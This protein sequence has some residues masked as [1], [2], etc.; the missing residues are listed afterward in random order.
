MVVIQKQCQKVQ[1]VNFRRLV[2][3]LIVRDYCCSAVLFLSYNSLRSPAAP[4][5]MSTASAPVAQWQ[6]WSILVTPEV[7][8]IALG[9]RRMHSTDDGASE[10]GGCSLA[11]RERHLLGY[12][13]CLVPRGEPCPQITRAFCFRGNQR[14]STL[15]EV[16]LSLHLF[17]S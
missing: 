7:T 16:R 17:R 8:S 9:G 1:A 5:F 11:G 12:Y 3:H 10:G 15:A 6:R 4:E 13:S 2:L 14:F